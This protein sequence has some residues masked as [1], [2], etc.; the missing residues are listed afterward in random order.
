[1]ASSTVDVPTKARR[2]TRRGGGSCATLGWAAWNSVCEAVDVMVGPGGIP[3]SE[4]C[5]P[6]DS[7]AGAAIA[8]DAPT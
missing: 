1:M 7:P 2:S 6:L 4:T 8:A 3:Q 5:A